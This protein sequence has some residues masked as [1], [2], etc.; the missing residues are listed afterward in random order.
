MALGQY[1]S[2]VP[3]RSGLDD[4]WDD[5]E[6]ALAFPL[7]LASLDSSGGSCSSPWYVCDLGDIG[8]K[9]S[10]YASWILPPSYSVT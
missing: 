10:D 9:S 6:G 2:G 3:N 8:N 4:H 1:L 7:G 5:V